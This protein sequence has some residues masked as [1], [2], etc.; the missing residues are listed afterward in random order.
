M[1]ELTVDQ[2]VQRL[3]NGEKIQVVD[4]REAPEH[5]DWSIPGSMNCPA[6]NAIGTGDLSALQSFVGKLSKEKQVVTVCRGGF[7]SQSAAQFWE[8]QGFDVLNLHGGMGA[9][10][11]ASSVAEIELPGKN[12]DRAF[13]IRRNGKGCLSYLL[14]SD[15]QAVVIDPSLQPKV[16]AELAAKHKA[17]IRFVIDTHVHADHISRGRALASLSR[18]QYLLPIND[19]V[20]FDY[21]SIKSDQE[22]EIGRAKLK[23]IHT[24]GHTGESMCYLVDGELLFSGDTIFTDNVGRPDLEKGDSGAEAGARALFTS[25]NQKVLRLP[26]HVRILPAHTGATIGF[27]SKVICTTVKDIKD[28]LKSS[29]GVES[30]FVKTVVGRLTAKPGNFDSVIAVNEGKLDLAGENPAMLEAG[31]N[32]CAAC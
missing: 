12:I 6:Y 11:L 14:I 26:D 19:R 2:L 23:A 18:A 10:S 13:Q 7:R 8:G 20:K 31:P 24:P 22:I 32:R 1:K 30:D 5:R 28:L 9:W 29:I 25:L 16:Y 21:D 15:G 3:S 27:D 17:K 4:I